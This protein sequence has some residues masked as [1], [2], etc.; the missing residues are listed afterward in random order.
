M[1]ADGGDGGSSLD[2]FTLSG[3]KLHLK[4]DKI[5]STAEFWTATECFRMLF[6][7]TRSTPCGVSFMA[8]FAPPPL[9]HALDDL[10][11]RIKLGFR[12]RF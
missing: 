2:Y 7:S 6:F 9:R 5:I 1:H 8:H 12:P 10:S 3:A 4:I 11:F